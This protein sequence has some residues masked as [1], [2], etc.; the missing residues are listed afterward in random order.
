MKSGAT[1]STYC[2][3]PS[4]FSWLG[5][6]TS[7]RTWPDAVNRP[8]LPCRSSAVAALV[9]DVDNNATRWI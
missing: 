3:A 8:T 6:G 5:R 9:E 4:F 1:Y 2:I 7:F